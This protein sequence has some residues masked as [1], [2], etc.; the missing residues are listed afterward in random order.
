LNVGALCPDDSF[1]ATPTTGKAVFRDF[2]QPDGR[3][4]SAQA[5]RRANRRGLFSCSPQERK[6]AMKMGIRGGFKLLYDVK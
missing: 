4:K 3:R 2:L 6:G 1:R 5:D